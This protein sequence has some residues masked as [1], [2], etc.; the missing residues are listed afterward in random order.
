MHTERLVFFMID[1]REYI[2]DEAYKLFLNHSYEA[3]SISIISE[4]IGLTKG[5]L[6]HHFRN[7]E[8]LYRAV[9]DKHFAITA[10][11]VDVDS[12]SLKDYTDA[13]IQHTRKILKT[14]F[15]E[16]DQ[17]IPINYL[18]LIADSFRHYEGFA[19]SKLQ[20]IDDEVKNVEII[21]KNAI[22]RSEIRHDIDV[23]IVALQYFSMSMGA[24]PEIS[25]GT[26]PSNRPSKRWEINLTS[27]TNF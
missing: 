13:C 23:H 24:S 17:F 9:I 8:E 16:E 11:A 2:I 6:Y 22:Q 14:I 18:S 1:T 21:I 10:V 4:A 3:V 7:K 5:A 19:E 15:R 26:A 12:I 20:F 25:C 27:C